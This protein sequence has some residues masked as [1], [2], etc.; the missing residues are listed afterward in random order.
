MIKYSYLHE[1]A[2]KFKFPPLVPKG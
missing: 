2:L 1:V